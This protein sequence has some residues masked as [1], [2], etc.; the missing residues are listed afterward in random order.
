MAK[1]KKPRGPKLDRVLNRLV[2]GCSKMI[3]GPLPVFL[4]ED[5]TLNNACLEYNISGFNWAGIIAGFSTSKFMGTVIHVPNSDVNDNQEFMVEFIIDSNLDNYYLMRQWVSLYKSTVER[6]DSNSH[7]GEQAIWDAQ[8]AWCDFVDIWVVD[9]MNVPVAIIRYE[10]VF[11]YQVG[12]ITMNF[13][14]AQE[15]KATANFKYNKVDIIRNPQDVQT[16]LHDT[17]LA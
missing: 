2:Q 5:D 4:H 14:S 11:C 6:L 8:R 17:M 9:N 7:I 12:D 15:L 3:F 10:Q 16:I 1:I 13:N